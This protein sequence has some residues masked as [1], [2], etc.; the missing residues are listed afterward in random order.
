MGDHVTPEQ[1]APIT[2][3]IVDGYLKKQW[4]RVV[5]VSMH[6]A[7]ALRQEPHITRVLPID[8]N[9]IKGII[10]ETIPTTGRFADIIKES[11]GTTK[12]KPETKEYLVEPSPKVVLKSLAQH[13]L[14]MQLYHI[15]LEA[16]ASE[17]SA[18]R[19]AMKTASDN[20]S[21]LLTMLRGK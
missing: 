13:L 5:V 6:F 7:S 11:V 2:Q 3:F 4:D 19:M 10:Q 16:N 18:R 1:V 21:E 20:A 17:H 8:Y 9:H 12:E 15:I 14:S